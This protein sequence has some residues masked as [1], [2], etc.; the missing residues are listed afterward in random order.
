MK[1][2]ALILLALVSAA[3]AA[4]ITYTRQPRC[5]QA[6][7][8]P[9]Y[10]P[11]GECANWQ[12]FYEAGQVNRFTESE[13]VIDDLKGNI[14]RIGPDCLNTPDICAVHDAR[15]SPDGM[16]ILYTVA[17]GNTFTRPKAWADGPFLPPIEFQG[18]R[19][20]IGLYD[21]ATKQNYLI[22]STAR[23]PDWADN[24]TIVFTSDRA[25]DYSP[26]SS[27]GNYY[28]MKSLHVYRAELVAQ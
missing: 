24:D 23:Q 4:D 12:H 6:I 27:A 15:V 2:Y 11:I 17:Y 16:R 21:M 18:L 3:S 26:W 9:G 10:A 22:E 19:Y 28:P 20:E 8:T 5:S 1:R 25:G 14:T 13:V 7:E